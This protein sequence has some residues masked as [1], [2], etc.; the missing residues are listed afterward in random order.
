MKKSFKD[1]KGIERRVIVPDLLTPADEGVPA[2]L[3]LQ[4][5]A[6]THN[7]PQHVIDA[8]YREFQARNLHEPGD[9]VHPLAP[10]LIRAALISVY[11]LDTQTIIELARMQQWQHKA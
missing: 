4:S 10:D 8:L 7:L 2:S 9:F 6:E 11:R 3:D 5:L 1:E